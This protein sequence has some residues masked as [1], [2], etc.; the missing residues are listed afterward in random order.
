MDCLFCKIA[1]AEIPVEKIY[2]DDLVIAFNDINPEAPVHVLIIPKKHTTS[3][4]E[5]TNEDFNTIGHIFKVIQELALKLNISEA[6]FRVIT[7][8][9]EDGGQSVG[10]LHFHLIGGRSMNWPPG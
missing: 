3:I 1:S 8:C 7:N 5:L 4:M 10:H 2:E 9:G 6:G